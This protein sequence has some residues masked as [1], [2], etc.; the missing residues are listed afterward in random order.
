MELT[1]SGISFTSY[2]SLHHSQVFPV[3]LICGLASLGWRVGWIGLLSSSFAFRNDSQEKEQEG[4][5]KRNECS[6]LIQNGINRSTKCGKSNR[7][8]RF[9]HDGN[10]TI[11]CTRTLIVAKMPESDF[12][13]SDGESN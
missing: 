6:I 8:A 2:P 5:E 4:N 10:V 9:L 7:D 12:H 13:N 3:K 1:C 11:S